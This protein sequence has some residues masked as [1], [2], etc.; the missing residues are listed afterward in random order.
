MASAEGAFA[1]FSLI[2]GPFHALSTVIAPRLDHRARVRVGAWVSIALWL[3][4]AALA[5][6]AGLAD[7]F[8]SLELSAVHVRMLVAV[9]LILW[10]TELFDR[11]V[12]DACLALVQ[13]GIVSGG[14]KAA[15][16]AQAF[17][18]IRFNN[19]WWLHMGLMAAV[20][21]G[22]VLAP[23]SFLPGMSSSASNLS[24]MPPTMA[25][26]WY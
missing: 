21:I 22:S 24:H 4:L 23:P 7:R 13:R 6:A 19:S 18:L 15:L 1:R 17:R 20:V 2:G 9:P 25:G 3:I 26:Y 12:Q 8:F 10:C 11:A 16:D 14:A 5:T